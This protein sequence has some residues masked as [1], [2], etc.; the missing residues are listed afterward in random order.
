M[1][2][3]MPVALKRPWFVLLRDS[4]FND[5]PESLYQIL[6]LWC[7][8]Q[9]LHDKKRLKRVWCPHGTLGKCCSHSTR[10][11]DIQGDANGE[12]KWPSSFLAF[13]ASL[14][15]SDCMF[16]SGAALRS[17][18]SKLVKTQTV[19]GYTHI[20][21]RLCNPWVTHYLA[22]GNITACQHST[23]FVN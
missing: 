22:E 2:L 10:V 8:K 18:P 3:V 9:T 6:I 15:P 1:N 23:A 17:A 16:P 21:G 20:D 4:D 5:E 7:W 11:G 13:L 12:T 14:S 19:L